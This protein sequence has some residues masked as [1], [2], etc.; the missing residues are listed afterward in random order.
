MSKDQSFWDKVAPS[1]VKSNIKDAISYEQKLKKTQ[2][3]LTK[4]MSIMEVACGTG[5]TAIKHA[6]FVKHVHATDISPAMIKFAQDRAAEESVYNISFEVS[7]INSL[8][9]VDESQ[10]AI[11]AMSIL[12]LLSDPSQGLQTLYK[13]L[14]PGG[15]LISSTICLGDKLNFLKLIIPLMR[16]VGYA[17]S[18]V[19]FLKK[20][21]Y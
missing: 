20:M 13:K 1:Y 4:D 19:R 18:V 16:L 9:I 2:E 14:K 15:I 3:Y 12:H 11:L 7:D 5:M 17:P 21:N 6:P 8:S 10:D